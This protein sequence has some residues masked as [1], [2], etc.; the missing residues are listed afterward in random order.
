MLFEFGHQ[1]RVIVRGVA[2]LGRDFESTVKWTRMCT[3][4]MVHICLLPGSFAHGRLY[5]TLEL[6]ANC[7]TATPTPCLYASEWVRF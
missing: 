3:S 2:K 1:S 4:V 5:I 6:E 7:Y